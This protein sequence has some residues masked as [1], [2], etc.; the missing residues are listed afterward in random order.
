LQSQLANK[1]KAVVY[2]ITIAQFAVTLLITVI[3]FIVAGLQAA[4][5]A[6]LA[7]LISTLSTIFVGGRFFFST[8]A[9]TARD[10]LASIYIAELLKIVFVV[11]AFCAGFLLLDI[12]F[13]AFIGAYLATVI[14]YWLAMIWPVFGVQI[15]MKT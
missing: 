5:S 12:H 15:K 3:L 1:N 11:I 10:R 4:Y 9:S 13:P 8:T 6:L 14:V 7:G 2:R